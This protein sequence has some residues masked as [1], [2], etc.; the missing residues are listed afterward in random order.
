MALH[1]LDASA[2]LAFLKQEP[3]WQVVEALLLD[4]NSA[5]HAHAINL[6]EVYY[7]FVRTADRSTAVAAIKDLCTAGVQ[8]REDLDE[9]FWQDV[10]DMI[11]AARK[12]PGLAL[13]LADA[14]GLALAR[15]LGC[16]FVAD[17]HQHLDPLL[18]LNLAQVRF[19][20]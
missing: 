2:M 12:V 11:A 15:R 1:A 5:C 17:D 6:C 8:P 3:G 7:Y 14:C 19:I 16:E 10:G 20:R 13:S 9:P 4:P 18:P